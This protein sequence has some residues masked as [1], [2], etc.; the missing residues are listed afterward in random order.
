MTDVLK[1]DYATSVAEVAQKDPF[2]AALMIHQHDCLEC[3]KSDIQVVKRDQRIAGTAI[4]V[5][6][7]PIAGE[8]LKA[9]FGL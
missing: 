6:L 2:L 4:V 3:T 9:L 8:A 7:L 5:L 1:F